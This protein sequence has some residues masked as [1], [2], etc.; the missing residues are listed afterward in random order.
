MGL[1]VY[2]GDI[3]T[4]LQ[5]EEHQSPLTFGQ[6][7]KERKDRNASKIKGNIITPDT[8]SPGNIIRCSSSKINVV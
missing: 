6:D 2:L 4:R 1:N 3:A 5:K 7:Y 8:K